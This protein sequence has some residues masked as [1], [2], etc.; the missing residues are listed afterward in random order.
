MKNKRQ[1]VDSEPQKRNTE[2]S[3]SPVRVGMNFSKP[4]LLIYTFIFKF[5][6]WCIYWY[7][8]CCT[9]LLIHIFISMH[10]IDTLHFVYSFDRY[11][12]SFPFLAVMHN[13]NMNV[14]IQVFLW[15][16]FSFLLF[17]LR[18][19]IVESYDNSV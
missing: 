3:S 6:D 12:S 14:C 7:Y 18:Y 2:E 5:I 11:L 8:I 19:G 17:I 10:F 9:W 4:I 1:D 16:F 15:T 13:A